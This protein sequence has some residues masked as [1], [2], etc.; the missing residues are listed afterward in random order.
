MHD[1]AGGVMHERAGSSGVPPSCCGCGYRIAVPNPTTSGACCAGHIAAKR[2]A[3]TAI[4]SSRWAHA[5]QAAT[6][7]PLGI[8]S[9]GGPSTHLAARRRTTKM[10]LRPPRAGSCRNASWTPWLGL[11][12]CCDARGRGLGLARWRLE[13]AGRMAPCRERAACALGRTVWGRRWV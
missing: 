8:V 3:A 7:L 10:K 12:R 5:T 9:H 4:F 1:G 2:G 11:S 6:Q 13:R